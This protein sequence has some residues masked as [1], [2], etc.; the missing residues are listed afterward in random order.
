[1]PVY[2][3]F[4]PIKSCVCSSYTTKSPN[5]H[6]KQWNHL[7]TEERKHSHPLTKVLLRQEVKRWSNWKD[8]STELGEQI[9]SVEWLMAAVLQGF[10]S[11][12]PFAYRFS[13]SFMRF[14][15]IRRVF[16]A[17]SQQ[18]GMQELSQSIWWIL[19][20][21][22][23]LLE[24]QIAAEP[25]CVLFS[26]STTLRWQNDLAVFPMLPRCLCLIFPPRMLLSLQQGQPK[27]YVTKGAP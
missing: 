6:V 20:K 17:V 13:F 5:L 9:I 4:T 21:H 11:E 1:M 12:F 23:R 25:F 24:L 27:I 7:A 14:L 22:F 16:R 2:K 10:T 3:Y 26:N 15:D 19:Q 18:L 8:N